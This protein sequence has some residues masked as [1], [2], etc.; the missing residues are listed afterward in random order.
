MPCLASRGWAVCHAVP[1]LAPRGWAVCRVVPCIASRGCAVRHAVPCLA[2]RGWAVCRVVPFIVSGFYLASMI[3]TSAKISRRQNHREETIF[4]IAITFFIAVA[5]LVE[6]IF[7]KRF[8]LFSTTTV[9]VIIYYMVLSRQKIKYDPL[10]GA[11]NRMVYKQKLSS[12]N[13]NSPCVIAMLDVNKLKNINDSFGHAKGDF[14]LGF[15]SDVIC[16]NLTRHML[17]YR[18]GGDEFVIIAEKN[19]AP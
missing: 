11:Y 9:C 5:V 1:C 16:Q 14:V 10:S 17:F 19:R 18:I 8:M 4:L 2:P 12:L 7:V 6:V 15:V 3:A 13:K